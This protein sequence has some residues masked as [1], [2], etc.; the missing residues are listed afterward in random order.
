MGAI[1][2]YLNFIMATEPVELMTK[3]KRSCKI[4]Q[5]LVNF[6]SISLFHLKVYSQIII[7]YEW[8]SVIL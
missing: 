5:P 1:E 7:C 8:Q 2:F 6:Q 3:L 4:Q